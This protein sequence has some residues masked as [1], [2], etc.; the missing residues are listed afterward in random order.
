M[1]MGMGTGTGADTD[2]NTGIST[3]TGTGADTGMAR[4]RIRASS[5]SPTNRARISVR[6]RSTVNTVASTPSPWHR[7]LDVDLRTPAEDPGWVSLE[8]WCMASFGAVRA[9]RCLIRG[10]RETLPVRPL[11]RGRCT[12]RRVQRPRH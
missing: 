5:R 2:T 9:D 7:C 12:G 3:G 11:G 8:C 6:L 1:G 4:V 10:A